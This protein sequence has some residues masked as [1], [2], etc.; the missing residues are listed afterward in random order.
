MLL[1]HRHLTHPK[2]PFRTV[3]RSGGSSMRWMKVLIVNDPLVCVAPKLEL[4]LR[5][6]RQSTRPVSRHPDENVINLRL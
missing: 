1:L 6:E 4:K 2:A 3:G 5:D